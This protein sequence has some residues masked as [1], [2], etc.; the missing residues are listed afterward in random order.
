MEKG[1]TLEAIARMFHVTV[2]DL[3]D[4]NDIKNVDYII[5][6]QRILIP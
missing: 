5:I 4:Y 2:Q 6:G 3:A 1:D